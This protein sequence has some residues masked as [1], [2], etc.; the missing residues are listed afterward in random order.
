MI[1]IIIINKDNNKKKEKFIQCIS[2]FSQQ[3]ENKRKRK[4]KQ[5]FGFCS[6]TEKLND[7]NNGDT[8]YSWCTWKETGELV[9]RGIIKK[10]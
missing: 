10:I 5:I 3:S 4:D 2:L 6:R 9:T 1:I 8:N 7:E